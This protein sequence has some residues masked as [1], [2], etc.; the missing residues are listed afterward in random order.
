MTGLPFDAGSFKKSIE[1]VWRAAA[2]LQISELVQECYDLT[3]AELA[4]L[5][6]YL[7][8]RKVLGA[9]C[10]H[11]GRLGNLPSLEVSILSP[12]RETPAGKFGLLQVQG[13]GNAVP[14]CIAELPDGSIELS[15][16]HCDNEHLTAYLRIPKPQTAYPVVLSFGVMIDS[17]D[18][19]EG[20]GLM[21]PL[22]KVSS[23][24]SMSSP[25]IVLIKP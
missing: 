14:H 21:H 10:L 25:S 9:L 17:S 11:E 20:P 13:R 5:D 8:L 2:Q 23:W 7:R 24:V 4:P 1:N 16:T 12:V 19:L 15:K 6:L 22:I 3:E 18:V